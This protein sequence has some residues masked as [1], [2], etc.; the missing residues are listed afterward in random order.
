[1][2]DTVC[3][4]LCMDPYT[5]ETDCDHTSNG[6]KGCDPVVCVETTEQCA[7]CSALANETSDSC[8]IYD[9]L[10]AGYDGTC[11]CPSDGNEFTS[12]AN[13]HSCEG[14]DSPCLPPPPSPPP[15]IPVGEKPGGCDEGDE[16]DDCDDDDDG[17][18]AAAGSPAEAVV[19][20]AKAAEVAV[21]S[22]EMLAEQVATMER[23]ASQA[24]AKAAA[25]KTPAELAAANAAAEQAN[26]ALME[27]R[28][29]ATAAALAAEEASA[30]ALEVAERAYTGTSSSSATQSLSA[31]HTMTMVSVVFV[32]GIIGL[33]VIAAVVRNS[34]RAREPMSAADGADDDDAGVSARGGKLSQSDRSPSVVHAEP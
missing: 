29:R 26:T 9:V 33:A 22:A 10:G 13:L 32:A 30:Y 11:G 18:E 6:G 27:A 15:K 3:A 19:A 24:S 34:A 14:A 1:M 20:A 17:D 31:N 8:I 16:G 2:S 28:R 7:H 23:T 5:S 12:W 25:A 4:A 21:H